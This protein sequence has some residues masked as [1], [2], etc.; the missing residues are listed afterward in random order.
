MAADIA[1]SPAAAAPKPGLLGKPAVL[2]GLMVAVMI[3]EFGVLYFLLPGPTPD[4]AAAVD[5][6]AQ[7]EAA[8]A[9]EVAVDAFST[10]NGRAAP[11][12]V[13]HI[14]FKLVALVA[15]GEGAAFDLAANT[16][17]KARVRQAVYQVARSASLEDLND[18]NLTTI[19]RQLR[20]Q[21]NKVLRKSF[22]TEV[23]ISDFKTME[24]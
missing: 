17:H 11:G 6:A 24:Q 15:A 5:A 14:S 4:P 19:R 21:I 10:T 20:E 13:I 18:P 2:G 3:I 8:D 22:V 12:S 16:N 23:V 9:V 7:E 1:E